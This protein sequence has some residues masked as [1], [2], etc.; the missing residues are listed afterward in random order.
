MTSTLGLPMCSNKKDRPNIILIIG[1]DISWNDLG[2]YGHP[3]IRTPNVDNLAANGVRF[4]RAFLTASSCSPSRCS[5]ITGRYPHN[6]G[7]AELHTPLPPDQLPFPL[8]LK[9]NGYYCAQGGKWHMGEETKRAFDVI[10]ETKPPDDPGR[11]KEWLPLLQNRPKD[12]PFFMWFASFDAHR[13]WDD[14][15]FLIRHDP[16]DVHVPKYLVDAPKT[17]QDIA[18]YYDEVARLDY[19]VGEVEK[20]LERQGIAENTAI[21]FMADNGRPFP[22]CKTRVY[23]SGMKTPFIIK[24]PKGVKQTGSVC[25]SLISAIDIGPTILELAG[26]PINES[27]QGCSFASLLKNPNKEFRRYVF[28]EHNWHNHEALERMVRSR[29]FLYVLNERPQF[30]N[31]GPTDSNRSDSQQDLN[32][33]R[34]AGT[35]TPEQNDVFL[36]PRPHEELF[37]VKDDPEQFENVADDPKYAEPLQEMRQIMQRWRDETADTTPENLTPDW[38]A[39]FTAEKLDIEHVR[40][41]MPGAAKNAERVNMEGPF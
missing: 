35:L 19:Y 36:A 30:S 38:N 12:K 24:W 40:G 31:C 41:E 15:I 28:S 37:D 32:A 17:R 10:R 26:V 4:T 1:D 7:A 25:N 33:R 2:C 29:D 23:D 13:T 8:R 6:T 22:R 27:F 3:T 21:I 16:A 5:I 34:A 9:E 39:R 18:Y 11:E 20:E 14:Q